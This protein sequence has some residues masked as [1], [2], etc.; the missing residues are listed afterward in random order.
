[1]EPALPLATLRRG[2]FHASIIRDRYRP[3][4]LFHYIIQREDEAEI[5]AWGQERS[6]AMARYAAMRQM[7]FMV[8]TGQVRA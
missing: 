2:P 5:L 1:L 7:D 4:K 8:E 6:L 3:S